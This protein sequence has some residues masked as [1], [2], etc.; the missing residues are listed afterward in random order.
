MV[1]AVLREQFPQGSLLWVV[2][3]G[4][5]RGR[6][7]VHSGD[8]GVGERGRRQFFFRQLPS[9]SQSPAQEPQF[10]GGPGSRVSADTRT[11]LVGGS[12]AA[13]VPFFVL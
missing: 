8:S 9:A 6:P 3:A 5:S 11:S 4:L 10:G 13:L 2:S 12:V 1:L 7:T